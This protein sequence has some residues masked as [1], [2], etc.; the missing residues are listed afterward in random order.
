MS[1][2]IWKL[3]LTDVAV[4]GGTQSVINTELVQDSHIQIQP[5]VKIRLAMGSVAM[6]QAG[7]TEG[8]IVVLKYGM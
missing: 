2:V 1:R 7:N 6:A 4:P 8:S 5:L 3:P